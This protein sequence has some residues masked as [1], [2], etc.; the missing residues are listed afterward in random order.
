M[1]PSTRTL[2]EAEKQG[3]QTGSLAWRLA[4]GET[5]SSSVSNCSSFQLTEGEIAAKTFHVEFDVVEDAYIRVSDNKSVVKGWQNCVKESEN[6]ARK[7]ELDWKMVYL[8][9]TGKVLV[10]NP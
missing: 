5:G 8:A 9:R 2:S 10:K 4:R 7:E 3:R 6:V 1:T